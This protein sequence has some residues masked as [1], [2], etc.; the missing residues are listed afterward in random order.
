MTVLMWEVN[1]LAL[2]RFYGANSSP[3]LECISRPSP[4]TALEDKKYEPLFRCG[5]GQHPGPRRRF[6]SN[7]VTTVEQRAPPATRHAGDVLLRRL[8]GLYGID[9][10]DARRCGS[11]GRRSGRP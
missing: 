7:A 4:E 2:P 3:G 11:A 9:A 8:V 10:R 1:L 5:P 6:Q